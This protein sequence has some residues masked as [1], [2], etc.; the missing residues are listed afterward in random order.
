MN[1][2]LSRYGGGAHFEMPP[3]LETAPD[4]L[5]DLNRSQTKTHEKLIVRSKYEE[6]I[7]VNNHTSVWGSYWHPHFGWGY[8][9]CLGFSKHAQCRGEEQKRETI[10]KEYE[11]ELQVKREKEA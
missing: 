2:L 11:W 7:F 6:D 8:R 4:D 5:Q 9:C 1:E 10:K 3:E